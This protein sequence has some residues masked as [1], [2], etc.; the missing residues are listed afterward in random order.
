MDVKLCR[1]CNQ[2]KP[3][4]EFAFRSKS[5]GTL[6]SACK[7]CHR[8]YSRQHYR[9]NLSKYKTK[10]ARWRKINVA[11]NR[12]WIKDYKASNGCTYCDESEPAV[13]DLHHTDPSVKDNAV[14]NLVVYSLDKIKHEVSKCI[15][16]CANCHRRLHAGLL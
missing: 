12:D 14:A 13:L 4:S 8:E 16:V 11:A 1:K 3:V 10:A 7:S 6:M 9:D 2:T 5:S 15:V